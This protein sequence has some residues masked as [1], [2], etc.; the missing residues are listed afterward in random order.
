MHHIKFKVKL[1][2]TPILYW[3]VQICVKMNTRLE[4]IAHSSGLDQLSIIIFAFL[5]GRK[6]ILE[7][8]NDS[9]LHFLNTKMNW[10]VFEARNIKQFDEPL[11]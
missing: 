8:A 7:G 6:V 2:S 1:E 3:E 9:T 4:Y 5:K 11:I 10:Q